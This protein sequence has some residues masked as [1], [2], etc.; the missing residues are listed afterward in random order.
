M[1]ISKLD[2]QKLSNCNL[3]GISSIVLGLV[4]NRN[5]LVMAKMNLDPVTFY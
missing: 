2:E 3:I 5:Q 4:S 1:L